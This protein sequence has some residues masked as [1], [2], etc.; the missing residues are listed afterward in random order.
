MT[1]NSNSPDPRNVAR[2]ARALSP[3]MATA[4]TEQKNRALLA[5]R[6]ALDA[7]R[8]DI[9][10][11]NQQDIEDAREKG[12]DE[13]V[14][15]RLVFGAS[16]ID[17]RMASL[18]KIAAL[19]DPIGQ[20]IRRDAL[21]NGLEATRVRVPLG[22]IMMI[23]EARPHVSVNAGA[24]CMKSGNACILRGGS[25][26]RRCNGLLGQLWGD[27]LAAAGLPRDAIQMISGS[28]E[29][30][31]TLLQ[32]D[33]LIDLVIPRG[34]K[35]LIQ[36]VASQSRIPVVKHFAGLCHVYID[37]S[38]DP[39]QASE[40][41]YDSKCLMPEVCNALET[42]LV[43][44]QNEAALRK[45]VAD[46]QRADVTV[47]GCEKTQSLCEEVEAATDEDWDTEYLDKVVSVRMVPGLEE[48][49]AHINAHGSHHTDSIVTRDLASAKAFKRGVDSGV[50]LVN[51][52]TMF[53]D[54]ETLGMG[55]EI[56]I[57][58]DKLH[59]RGPMGLEELT[60]YKFIIEGDGH[61]MGT[62]QGS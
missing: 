17:S 14:L 16:K 41:V 6:D 9:V 18:Q 62:P 1:T 56:G 60:S 48:A 51:A 35:N 43:A 58:T 29:D 24:F 3:V 33:D 37:A 23:Y 32:L 36:A 20:S 38:A 13:A 15:N 19:P 21:P 34:G 46:L 10:E 54:G 40:I 44:G 12:I 11:A 47:K 49:I 61:I 53:C 39:Q 2:Q 27:S 59:A 42:V 5:M 30:V 26:A 57:S 4:T 31:N 52:S 7:A 45:V 28:H 55:A 22:V 25:E 8:Q 50:V